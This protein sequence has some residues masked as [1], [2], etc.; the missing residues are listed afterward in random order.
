ML[1]SLGGDIRCFSGTNDLRTVQRVCNNDVA[2]VGFTVYSGPP[3][4]CLKK[5]IR[6]GTW[7]K[8]PAGRDAFGCTGTYV[9]G[10]PSHITL[11]AVL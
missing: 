8:F 3:G 7:P 9:K 11:A 4:Y 5:T 1:D 6:V 10:T 2:C